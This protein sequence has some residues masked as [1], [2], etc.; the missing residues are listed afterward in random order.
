[1]KKLTTL[2]LLLPLL[3]IGQEYER[4]DNESG[5]FSLGVRNTVSMF[6]DDG[7]TGFGYGAQF[8][9]RVLQRINTDWYGDYITTD[10]GGLGRRCDG[11]IGW[12]VLA[13]PLNSELKKGKLTP[14]ITAG[15]CFDY[16]RVSTNNF[17][18]MVDKWSSAVHVGLG[19][20]YN[21]TDRMDIS[22]TV[23]YMMH[24]GENIHAD[25]E[26][27]DGERVLV[28]EKEKASGVEGH[29]LINLSM[30]VRL[31]DMWDQRRKKA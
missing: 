10:I 24:I 31:F 18:N 1:M 27:I 5:H 4:I 11:H 26:N 16:T 20:H 9:I 22:L 23:Q 7:A 8:R 12:S 6:S 13:Y 15:N 29:M 28:I 2:F 19:T 3:S 14:Y 17:D 30:N 21:V 25:I